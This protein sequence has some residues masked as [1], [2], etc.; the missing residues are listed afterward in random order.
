[1]QGFTYSLNQRISYF[2]TTRT[3]AF[4][5]AGFS[6]SFSSNRS[7]WVEET[8]HN[9]HATISAGATYFFSPQLQASLAVGGEYRWSNTDRV[10][11]FSTYLSR[12]SFGFDLV[13]RYTFF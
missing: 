11:V 9:L 8:R 12:F 3:S 6:H 10:D 5:S 2:P 4:A 1:M 7:I 13:V